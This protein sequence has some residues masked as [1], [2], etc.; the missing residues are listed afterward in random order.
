M[1][2]A[3]DEQTVLNP[4][5]L[6]RLGVAR[7]CDGQVGCKESPAVGR[8]LVSDSL[9]NTVARRGV[10]P[11]D[12]EERRL[13]LQAVGGHPSG[14]PLRRAR[15]ARQQRLHG[16]PPLGFRRRRL[17]AHAPSPRRRSLLAR[18][19]RAA[20][21]LLVRRDH[22]RRIA[23]DTPRRRAEGGRRTQSDA[24]SAFPLPPS[25]F[26]NRVSAPL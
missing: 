4:R 1:R 7:R 24:L 17:I 19:V 10:I 26:A 22:S 15:P 12:A 16:A 8:H 21:G 9:R 18:T 5:W 11:V 23:L 25:P 13:L 6:I 14:E 2:R 3:T 20:R